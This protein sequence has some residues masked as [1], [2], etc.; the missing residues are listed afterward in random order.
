MLYEPSYAE[1]RKQIQMDR[2]NDDAS[3]PHTILLVEDNPGDARL[4]KE[5]CRDMGLAD[6][7][8]IVST[9]SNALDFVNQR[10]EYTDAP[11]TDLVILDWHLPDR[12][13]EGILD[14]LNSDPDHDHIPVI[15][16]T[17]SLPDREVHK[18]YKK[19]ANACISKPAG[20]D[21]LEETIRA[22][23]AFWLSTARLPSIDI[24][25]Q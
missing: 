8:H 16:T 18:A 7:L 19:N 4:V 6:I 10:G 2:P 25:E 17:G 12:G 5:I 13:G 9:V 15:V 23:E 11:R 1:I 3:Q 22:F 21:E 20:P 24:G 14:E